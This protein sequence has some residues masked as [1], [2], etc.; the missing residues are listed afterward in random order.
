MQRIDEAD[1]EVDFYKDIA[2]ANELSRLIEW[3]LIAVAKYITDNNKELEAKLH[4][5]ITSITPINRGDLGAIR[6][7]TLAATAFI[8]FMCL[9]KYRL[10]ACVDLKIVCSYT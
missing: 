6:V 3:L 4:R 10:F 1:E 5:D 9:V 8:K 7:D 2:D